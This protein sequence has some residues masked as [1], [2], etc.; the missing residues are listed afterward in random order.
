M[1][2][3]SVVVFSGKGMIGIGPVIAILFMMYFVCFIILTLPLFLELIMMEYGNCSVDARLG[4]CDAYCFLTKSKNPLYVRLLILQIS[5][6]DIYIILSEKQMLR[7]NVT[8]L[9][10]IPPAFGS[11]FTRV[12]S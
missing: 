12:T 3:L 5:V 2:F 10:H 11:I 8:V 6:R 4:R 9:F 1:L 7:S